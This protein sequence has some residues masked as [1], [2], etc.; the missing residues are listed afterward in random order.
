[1]WVTALRPWGGVWV[2]EILGRGTNDLETIGNPPIDQFRQTGWVGWDG[3]DCGELDMG[4]NTIKK[5]P[6]MAPQQYAVNKPGTGNAWWGHETF[7]SAT[8]Q[9]RLQF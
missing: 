5:L 9:A 7:T 4:Y 3:L 1:V 2:P 6:T 8:D